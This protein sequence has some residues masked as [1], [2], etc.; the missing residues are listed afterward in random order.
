MGGKA[1]VLAHA[2]D[3]VNKKRARRSIYIVDKD[4]DDLLGHKVARKNV[5]YLDRYCIENYLFEEDAV[6]QIAVESNPKRKR[7]DLKKELKLETLHRQAMR[8][9]D[10]LF[11]LFFAVQRFNLGIKNCDCA[12]EQFCQKDK[13]WCIAPVNVRTYGKQVLKLSIAA[14]VVKDR[15]QLDK[16]LGGAFPK[17]GPADANIS[18]KFLLQAL[19][20]YLRV[21]ANVKNVTFDSLRYRLARNGQLKGLDV[22]REHLNAHLSTIEKKPS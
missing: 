5:F 16:F 8:S 21:K 20:H 22:F 11:R 19:F 10:G 18:G 6:L 14:G 3:P 2:M 13:L 12:P 4:F 15:A 17:D 9:F 7:R 1:K